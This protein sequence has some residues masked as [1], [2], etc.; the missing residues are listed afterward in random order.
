MDLLP[1]F[2]PGTERHD[3]YLSSGIKLRWYARGEGPTVLLLH[4]FPEL[5]VSWARQFEGLAHSF[6]LVAP[7]LRGY[8]G[9]DQPTNVA[10]YRLDALCDDV[11]G[12]IEALGEGPVHLVG[13]DWGGAIAWEVAARAPQ[14]LRSLAVC[15]CP[16]MPMM[17]RQITSWAQVRRSWYMFLFQLPRL[18]ELLLQMDPTATAQRIFRDTATRPEVFDDAMLEPYV[19]QFA[20]GGPRGIQAYRAALRWPRLRQAPVHVP[21]RL[22]W[23]LGDKILGPHLAE[24]DRYRRFTRD[25]DVVPIPADEA[26]HFVQMEAPEAVNRA[27]ATHFDACDRR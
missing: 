5:S 18:P 19:Q 27:L 15:N 21:T 24:A 25:F 23:G 3:S 22:I 26:G 7:D 14:K 9:S 16:P 17:F 8:G 10:A 13:H 20:A 11:T 1:Y 6:R 2:P 4:G 12:L